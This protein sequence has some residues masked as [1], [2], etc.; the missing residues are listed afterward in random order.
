MGRD[1]RGTVCGAGALLVALAAFALGPPAAQGSGSPLIGA[2]WASEVSASSAHLNAEIDANGS[3][4]TYHFDYITAAAY[5]ANVAGGKEG[6]AGAAR[7]PSPNDANLATSPVQQLLSNLQPQTAYRYRLVAKNSAG[8]TTSSTFSFATQSLGG[9][10]LLADGRGWEMVSPVDKN[11]GQADPP[12]ALFGGGVLQAAAAGGAVTYGSATSFGPSPVGAA[13]ASQYLAARSA[14]GWSAQNITPP[15]FSGSYGTEREGVPYQLFSPDLARG[16]LL[17]GRR[18]RGEGEGCAVANPPLAGTDAPE[19]YQ[20]YYLRESAGGA[21]TALLGTANAG[22]LGLEPADFELTL[23]GAAA[24][25]RHVVLSTCAALTANAVEVPLG[26]GCD[27]ARPNLYEYSPGAGLSLVN[28]RPG[29]T[30]GTPGAVLGAQGGAVSADGSRVY[31]RDLQNG[32][33]YLREGASSKQVDILAGGGG[34][35]ETATPAGSPAFYTKADHLYRYDAPGAGASIDLTP[36]GGVLG[37]LGAS[38]DGSYVYYLTSSGLFLRHGAATV[39]VA[40][41]ADASNYPPTTGT[42]R[43]SADGTRL[44][45][46]SNASLTGFDNTQVGEKTSCD[47]EAPFDKGKPCTEVYLYDASAPSLTCV[48]CNPT[49]GRP[50][51][52]STIPG[53]VP[54]GEGPAATDSYKPRALSADGRRVFFDSRDALALVDTNGEGDVYEWE[55]Q[56]TGS[57]AAAGGC[58]TPISSGRATGGASFVDASADGADAFFLTDGSLV[59]ADPGA[60]DLY[61]AR[62]GGGFPVASPPIACQGDACQVLPP[63]PVDPGLNTLLAGAGNPPVHYSHYKKP[64]HKTHR[65]KK[66]HHKKHGRRGARR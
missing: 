13:P 28:L 1:T 53:A 52:P 21:Y 49:N 6:F 39:P 57:C 5:E 60:V 47:R 19:G 11:G 40:P 9:G 7:A 17:N 63:E 64:H 30:Q 8:P 27:P 62:I 51:G 2:L 46:L 10:V 36:A 37:V 38:E 3:P 18:C 33:L 44:L 66:R 23:A 16:L 55:Q 20:N 58:L 32:N 35:F 22:Q 25:L 59:G 12:G 15:L 26:E 41:A 14:G 42:A 45:F 54:N 29:D 56:G 61:D 48:S 24:D 65:H 34:S 4:T 31:W 50:V 43:V